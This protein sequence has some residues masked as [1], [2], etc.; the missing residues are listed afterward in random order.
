MTYDHIT[1]KLFSI[2]ILLLAFSLPTQSQQSTKKDS[3]YLSLLFMGDIMGHDSQIAAAYNDITD[4]FDY[5]DCFMYVKSRIE[6]ADIAF[7]NLEVTLGIAPFKGY[8]QF[9]SPKELAIGIKESGIDV[10]VTANNHSCDKG[11][12]GIDKTI[13]ILDSLAFKRTGTFK[14]SIDYKTNHP[15]F[16]EKKG[17]KIALLNYTY[18]TNGLPIPKGRIVNL[19]N[20]QQIDKDIRT[21]K[22]SHPDI[23]IAFLHWGLEYQTTQNTKQIN[24]ANKL[25]QLGVDLVIGSH[26]HVLQPMEFNKM[27]NQVTIYSLGNFIS[28][29]RTSPRDGSAMVSI[30]LLKN[31]EGVKIKNVG[32]DLTYVHNPIVNGKRN[33]LIIPVSDVEK[34][35]YD[36]L[37][38]YTNFGRIQGYSSKARNILSKNVNIPEID[39]YPSV[40]QTPIS[41]NTLNSSH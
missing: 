8:P 22:N 28:A 30:N 7:A 14:D 38:K 29:Q 2:V 36:D 1:I 3:S 27:T 25:H 6:S 16:I 20:S 39:L 19:I 15:L 33:F 12:K 40:N 11:R 23:I 31:S 21:A 17:F 10:L 34:N 9:S 26:P 18:G 24:M 13:H 4:S 35:R 37:P 32:Y 41:L 5:S